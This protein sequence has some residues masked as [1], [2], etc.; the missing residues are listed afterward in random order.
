MISEEKICNL[1]F[2]IC[3]D[4]SVL[5]LNCEL[6]ES[7]ILDSLAFILLF[8]RLEDLGIEISPTRINR[9]VLKTPKSLQNFLN[10]YLKEHEK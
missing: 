2:E 6:L 3:D 9:D 5:D 10:Q 1:L 7:G 4:E 8:S